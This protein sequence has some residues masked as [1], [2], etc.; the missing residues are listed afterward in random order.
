PD[1]QGAIRLR[2]AGRRD[3]GTL[4][5]ILADC[6]AYKKD[7]DEIKRLNKKKAVFTEDLLAALQTIELATTTLL[8]NQLSL[9]KLRS[10][11]D[12]ALAGLNLEALEA[13][14]GIGQRARDRLLLYQY[15]LV[16][17]YQYLML[18]DLPQID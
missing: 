2:G 14:R 13:V 17:S 18:E 7:I 12:V 1:R 11:L 15:Y 10:Q 3:R 6:P 16:K 8:K 4:E 9:I 5:K